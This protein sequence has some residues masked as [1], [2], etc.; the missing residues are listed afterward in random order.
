MEGAVVG[1]DGG[2]LGLGGGFRMAAEIAAGLRAAYGME[3]LRGGGGGSADDVERTAAPVGGHLA[4]AAGWIGGCTDGLQQHV[5]GR[6]AQRQAEST[7]AIVGEKPVVS[8]TER[9]GSAHLQ[10]LVARGRNL[11]EDLLLP[12]E[13]DFAVVHAAGEVHQPVDFDHPLRALAP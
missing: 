6:D 8:G 11:E 13:Q 10:R 1:C 7:V 5:S 4:A 3:Q 12:F 2:R 9:Q